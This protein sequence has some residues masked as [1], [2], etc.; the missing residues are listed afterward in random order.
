M[1][2][3]KGKEL[4]TPLK[5]EFDPV[6]LVTRKPQTVTLM[7]QSTEENILQTVCEA[8]FK[9]AEKSSENKLQL[10][11]LGTL[12]YLT[13]LISHEEKLIKRAAIMSVGTIASEPSARKMMRQMGCIKPLLN[14][15]SPEEELICHE[16]ATL[17]LA[18]LA[19]EYVSKS[20]IL[21]QNGLNLLVNHLSSPDCDA[22]KNAVQA[23][24]LMVEEFQAR[25]A[26]KDF[27]AFE[28]LLKLLESEYPAIQ[29]L[30]LSTLITCAQDADNRAVLRDLEGMAKLVDIIGDEALSDLHFLA[31]QCLANCLED[32][33][34]L[35]NIQSTGVF[36]KLLAFITGSTSPEVQQYTMQVIAAASK[37]EENRK[38]F[39]EQE[40]EKTLI[41]LLTSDNSQVVTS[42]VKAIATLSES[43][44]SRD[45]IGKLDGIP[46]IIKLL[47]SD[48]EETR[49]IASLAIANL[50]NSNNNNCQVLMDKNGVDVLL[51]LLGDQN[52]QI[53]CNASITISNLAVNENWR[54][55]IKKQDV[56]KGLL[57]PLKSDDHQV[58]L[59]GCQALAS[60]MCDLDSRNKLLS[61]DEGILHVVNLLK[62][63]SGSV[64]R[65][66][67]WVLAMLAVDSNVADEITKHGG[68]E[69]LQSICLS[70]RKNAVTEMAWER[71]LNSNLPAKYSIT[72]EL[73]FDNILENVF[74][75]TGKMRPSEDFAPL[76]KLLEEPINN[77]RPVI[78]V[79]PNKKIVEKKTRDEA[80]SPVPPNNN[81]NNN[82]KT[83]KGNDKPRNR[84]KNERRLSKSRMGGRDK[85]DAKDN[86]DN[87]SGGGVGGCLVVEK[88]QLETMPSESLMTPPSLNSIA[89]EDKELLAAIAHV[90]ATVAPLGTC[91]EQ[92]REL[93]IYVS[94][95][96]GSCISRTDLT[97][98][99]YELH[100]SELKTDLGSNVIPI[101]KIKSGIYYHR[102][103]LFKV[104]ADQI[105]LRCNLMR[106]DYGRAWNEVQ[107]LF[108]TENG[109]PILPPKLFV[110][111]LMHNPGDLF[112]KGS[113]EAVKYQRI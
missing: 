10:L 13:K 95:R 61:L 54:S 11:D 74:Y 15:L 66:A 29:E 31:L 22:Q 106:G 17:A 50:T 18:N 45:T 59:N 77:K 65:N 41:T 87:S 37:L 110:V 40:T 7:L 79:N 56:V 4:E 49:E 107:I 75:D 76:T 52:H 70:S 100:M 63:P 38:I 98:F 103:L 97:N 102:A 34:T 90:Q 44:S 108:R 24:S 33:E 69:L 94:D 32:T 91:T 43:L 6:E 20:E 55:E 84:S 42:S 5:E 88:T 80:K 30:A 3:K 68:L 16:F 78:L 12:E 36:D 111:D 113:P 112:P 57:E 99:S 101:G 35:K 89:P 109:Q 60:F 8:L 39:H 62:S 25:A 27:N 19:E 82:N 71:L 21:E 23:I 92:I 48:N 81:N 73:K 26:I 96:M 47:S 85:E 93:A 64:Q 86:K 14:L 104:L 1:G 46:P 67:A 105:S 72:G 2:K 83:E 9:F 28:P 58:Q 51:K 53:Q